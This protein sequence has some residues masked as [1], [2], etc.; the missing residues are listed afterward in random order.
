[1][2]AV[3][4]E[5][6]AIAAALGLPLEAEPDIGVRQ[7]YMTEANYTTGYSMAPGFAGIKAQD[8]LDNRYLT[9]DVGYTLVFWADLAE[10]VGVRTPVIDTIITMASI[11][12]G[13]DFRGEAAR[14][15]ASVGLDK[16]TAEQLKEL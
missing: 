8:Q 4:R 6:M 1:M 5:R 7:N 12:M 3:D 9:E 15:L 11:V 16:L 2:R 14:T 13:R 10:K